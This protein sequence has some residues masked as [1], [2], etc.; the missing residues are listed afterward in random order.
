MPGRYVLAVVRSI[1]AA[2]LLQLISTSHEWPG[3]L[4][5]MWWGSRLFIPIT[6]GCLLWE[7]SDHLLAIPTFVGLILTLNLGAWAAR[8]WP[9]DLLVLSLGGAVSVSLAVDH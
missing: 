4:A 9:A 5:G 6:V 1:S 2:L 7:M 3:M 8:G